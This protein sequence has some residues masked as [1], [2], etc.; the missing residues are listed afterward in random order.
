MLLAL[1]LCPWLLLPGWR[2]FVRAAVDSGGRHASSPGVGKALMTA[3]LG[4]PPSG[5]PAPGG[6]GKAQG[7]GGSR[8]HWCI[9]AGNN[10]LPPPPAARRP[11]SRAANYGLRASARA[12][13][14]RRRDP[15]G[16]HLQYPDNQRSLLLASP[17]TCMEISARLPGIKCFRRQK[18]AP[19]TRGSRVISA[20]CSSQSPPLLFWADTVSA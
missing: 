12:S 15:P 1:V 9:G 20:R 18:S 11:P 3:V 13:L 2:G 17:K 19:G 14:S 7:C 6:P 4:Q 10:A 16:L 8:S 5:V